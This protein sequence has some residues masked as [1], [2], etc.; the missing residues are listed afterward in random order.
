MNYMAL[1]P[2]GTL[3]GKGTNRNEVSLWQYRHSTKR[4]GY[5]LD[6]HLTRDITTCRKCSMEKRNVKDGTKRI[7]DH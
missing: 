6:V 1:P 2:S 3:S 4:K 7:V 5:G